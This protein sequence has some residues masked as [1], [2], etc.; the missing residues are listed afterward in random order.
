MNLF[1]GEVVTNVATKIAP[2]G[3]GRQEL[4]ILL[5][6]YFEVTVDAAV[7]NLQVKKT[8]EGKVCHPGQEHSIPKAPSPTELSPTYYPKV[9]LHSLAGN[10][11]SSGNHREGTSGTTTQQTKSSQ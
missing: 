3:I 8:L 1:T 9:G 7:A 5:Q 11:R 6:R 2:F 10:S 4:F